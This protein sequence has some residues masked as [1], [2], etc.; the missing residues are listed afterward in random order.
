MKL[1][2]CID[3]HLGKVKQIVGS[4]LT[5]HGMGV[6]ENYVSN[7]NSSFYAEIFKQ[8]KLLGGHIIMLGKGSE[9]AA[10][11]ALKTYP[12]G[13]QIGGGIC[14]DNAAYY[15][16]KGASHVI[17]T[18]YIFSGGDINFEHL[19]KISE[20]VGKEHIV[21]D[22]SCKKNSLGHY[23]VMTDRWQNFTQYEINN[24]NLETL[25][26]YC[27]EFL[28]HAVQVEG[29]RAGIDEELAGLLS[30]IRVDIPFTYAGGI[31]NVK[32]IEKIFRIS[33]GKMDITIGSA[34][35]IYGGNLPYKETLQYIEQLRG[36]NHEY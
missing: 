19:K 28:I 35:D 32:D 26:R 34:L 12:G 17:V 30:G 4:T 9:E 23:V 36:R 6:V 22:I 2:P 5:D 3:L 33:K 27:D 8:D 14:L 21:L 25:S 10:L 7:H 16:E 20:A 18:S 1:R 15:L 31:S 11:E 29:K 13:M 24:E